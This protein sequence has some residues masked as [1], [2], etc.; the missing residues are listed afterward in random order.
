MYGKTKN[1]FEYCCT[2][3]VVLLIRIDG[4]VLMP[5]LPLII[6]QL[7]GNLEFSYSCCLSS[8][9][10]RI[11]LIETLTEMFLHIF[12][13]S[14]FSEKREEVIKLENAILEDLQGFGTSI[15]TGFCSAPTPFEE[16]PGFAPA[17][18]CAFLD[19]YLNRYLAIFI[20]S[21]FFTN[22][23]LGLLA[24]SLAIP[25]SLHPMLI[26]TALSKSPRIA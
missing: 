7:L 22:L 2:A 18:A 21:F 11:V 12:H 1:S 20:Y 19:W 5:L 17:L 25:M 23:S 13:L 3:E 26:L 15:S 4:D 9:N 14:I 6:P 8:Q 10:L 24:Y 16:I